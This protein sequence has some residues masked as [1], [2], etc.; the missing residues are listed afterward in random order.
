MQSEFVG[1][2]IAHRNWSTILKVKE[3]KIISVY[4]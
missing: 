2:E 3:G 1:L 4:N